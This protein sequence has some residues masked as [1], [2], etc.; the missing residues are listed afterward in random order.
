MFSFNSFYVE[1]ISNFLRYLNN[2]KLI[3]IMHNILTCMHA[4]LLAYVHFTVYTYSYI[5]HS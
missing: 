4:D 3:L 2:S 1:L 5:P